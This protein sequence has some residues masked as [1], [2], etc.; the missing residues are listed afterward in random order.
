MSTEDA[1]DQR[2]QALVKNVIKESPRNDPHYNLPGL[3]KV[4][5]KTK[6]ALFPVTIKRDLSTQGC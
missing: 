5:K 4:I 1:N 6:R 3:P 2:R